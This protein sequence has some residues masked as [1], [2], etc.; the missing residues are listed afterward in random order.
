M[1]S[2][3]A[4]PQNVIALGNMHPSVSWMDW[5]IIALPIC[6]IID[7][8][9]WLL[10]LYKYKPEAHQPSPPELFAHHKSPPLNQSQYFVILVSMVTVFL[11]C[12]ESNI[13]GIVGDMGII[14]VL[15]LILFF[16]TGILNKDDFNNFLWTL[17]VLAMGGIALGKSVQ[18]SG[19]LGA[20]AEKCIPFLAS[21]SMFE[22]VLIM[23]LIVL[24]GTTFVSHSVGALILLPIVAE[25]GA[26]LPDPRPRTL[27]MAAS[28]IQRIYLN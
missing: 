27:V 11:W 26:Q 22:C 17:V 21:M 13:E 24:L 16:G 7:I 3:I 5:F 20:L 23:T 2:P 10:L 19:L 18:S 4:S 12:I 8:F 14:S 15:P 25:I 9:I 6:L 1:A 28:E